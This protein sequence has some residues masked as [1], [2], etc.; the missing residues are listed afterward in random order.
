MKQE[1][2]NLIRKAVVRYVG[3]Y[4]TVTEAAQS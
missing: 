4:N 1:Q 3:N 2:K